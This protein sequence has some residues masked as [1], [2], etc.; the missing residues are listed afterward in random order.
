VEPLPDL[1]SLTD[2]DLQ[3]LIRSLEREED[4]ISYRRRLLHGR[5]DLLRAE[6]VQRLRAQVGD[7]IVSTPGTEP[8]E[9]PLFE[10][11]G[12]VPEPHELEPMPD[13]ETLSDD[14]LREMI[15]SLE[16]EEDDISLRRRFLHG[17]ID[18]LRAARYDRIRSGGPVDVSDLARVLAHH[19]P[20]GPGESA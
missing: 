18:I 16:R 6:H 20:A 1:A 5:I 11:T 15:R 2:D 13:L 12:E 4:G 14:D 8:H 10:G 19:E 9:R 7:G 3:A 17:Q